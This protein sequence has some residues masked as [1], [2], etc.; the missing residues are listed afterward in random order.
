MKLIKGSIIASIL[1]LINVNASAQN[2]PKFRMVGGARSII[3]NQEIDVQDSIADKTTPKAKTG[4]YS[5][6]DLGFNIMP[7][8][9]TEILGMIRIKNQYGGFFGGGVNFDVRQLW[10]K[11]IL[12]DVIRYQLGDINIKQTPFTLYNH[13]EDLMRTPGPLN[14][15]FQDIANYESFYKS[16]TWLQQGLSLDFGLNFAKGIEEINVNG[17]VTRLNMTNFANTPERLLGGSTIDMV[18]NQKLSL[19][20]NLSSVFDVTGTAIDSNSFR[21]IVQTTAIRYTQPIKKQ[22]IE[23]KAEFGNSYNYFTYDKKSPTLYDYFYN[24]TVKYITENKRFNLVFGYLNVGPYFRSPGAQSKRID[25]QGILSQFPLYRQYQNDRPIH[26]Q[27]ILGDEHIYKTSISSK[28]MAYN[29][30]INNVLPYGLA[31]FNRKGFYVNGS[32]KNKNEHSEIQFSHYQLGE[33]LGQGTAAL[34]S[35]SMSQLQLNLALGNMLKMSKELKLTTT[36]IM[37]NTKRSGTYDFESIDLNSLQIAAGIEWEF[38]KDF[39]FLLGYNYLSGK[40][41]EMISERNNYTEVIDFIHFNSNIQQNILGT[42]LKFKFSKT[43]YL[44]FLYQMFNHNN[45]QN[46]FENYQMNQTNIIYNLT[47]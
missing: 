7:N 40:G 3:S 32:F 12:A 44:A 19:Q 15:I 10:I 1:S 6:I 5:L 26:L 14:Q 37:Q 46:N 47:F 39:Q 42:G 24:P 2:Q 20:Y 41:N 28:L 30:I 16:N 31:T 43:T 33:I 21:N 11:G 25:Y 4:G 18:L 8:K 13:N 27:D 45:K 29:P 34:K 36:L 35:F 23:F 9:Q 38:Y 17:Y 22:L